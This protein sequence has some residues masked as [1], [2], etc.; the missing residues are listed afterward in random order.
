MFEIIMQLHGGH[1][2][3]GSSTEVKQSAPASSAGSSSRIS[4]ATE[5]ERQKYQEM[6]AKARGKKS[7]IYAGGEIEK[8]LKLGE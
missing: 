4:S 3:G 5:T 8:A 7:T 1:G 2:G 6:L